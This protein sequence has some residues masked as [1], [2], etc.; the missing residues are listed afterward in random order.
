MRTE[1]RRYI[2]RITIG[3]SYTNGAYSRFPFVSS[4]DMVNNSFSI[5]VAGIAK[6]TFECAS[7]YHSKGKVLG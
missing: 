1:V 4:F 5:Q 2:I 7:V 3:L 6:R